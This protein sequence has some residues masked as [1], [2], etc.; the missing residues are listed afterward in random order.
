[1]FSKKLVAALLSILVT[2]IFGTLV[3]VNDV[4][5]KALNISVN[6]PAMQ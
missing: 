2:V 3:D 5:Y 6:T 1:M 4:I